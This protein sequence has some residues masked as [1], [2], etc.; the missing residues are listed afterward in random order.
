MSTSRV[1]INAVEQYE[2]AITVSNAWIELLAP[3]AELARSIAETDFVPKEMRNRPAAITACI[4]YGAEIGIGP[5][6]S[7]AKVD[8]INGRPAPRA[9]LGRALA[10]GAGHEIWV[11]EST[12]T[13]VRV[14][15]R[16]R[17]SDKVQTTCWTMDD[18]KKAGI[19]NSNYAKYPRQMLLAR[20]SAEL[21]RMMC[22]DVLG[23]VT[24]FAEEAADIDPAEPALT[25]DV[26][27]APVKATTRRR[28]ATTPALVAADAQEQP[29]LPDDI[30]PSGDGP[31]AA[32]IKKMMATFNDIGIKERTERLS[33][34][35]AA[36]RPVESSKDLTIDEAANV[37]TALDRVAAGELDVV[38]V[39]GQ[40]ELVAN[41]QL[42]PPLPDD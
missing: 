17:G 39:D 41:D 11:D 1:P 7:L 5:M 23:G 6:Q 42:Q 12:N 38:L 35:A 22:P 29:P 19:S 27:S 31:T 20:A 15:G 34:I 32:Q 25:A 21:V 14:S 33:F 30:P 4:L 3:A 18:V 28:A 2:P 26:A 24:V 16:R 36:V 13:R 9:E 40:I 8:I 37:I 10:L